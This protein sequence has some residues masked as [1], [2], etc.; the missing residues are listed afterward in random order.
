VAFA[1]GPPARY[2][3][4]CLISVEH[5]T[6]YYGATRA[7]DD[8]SF[9]VARGEVAALLGPNGSGKSTVMRLVIG[10]FSPTAGHVRVGG[11]DVAA[12]PV[13]ARGQV[14][15][16]PEQVTLYPDLTVRR[17][18]AFVAQVK[19]LAGRAARAAVAQVIESCGLGDVADRF[20]GTLSKGYRQRVGLAQALVGDPEVLV[21][22]EPT[23][24]LDPVQTVEMRGLLRGLA[25]RTLLLST[26]ILSEASALCSRIVIL[27]RGRLLAEDTPS[28]LARRLE[29][30]GR[31]TVRVEGP[32]GAVAGALAGIPGVARVE[33]TADDGRAGTAFVVR[34]PAPEPVQRQLAAVVVGH[35]WTRLEVRAEAPSLEDLFVRLVTPGPVREP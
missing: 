18:L 29:G 22:D 1:R 34:A 15:Y 19:G 23:V 32:P 14:G 11:L 35:G 8:V 33:R 7:V 27:A 20:A 4:A 26:H 13:A 21:L 2:S 16:L 6:K 3:F 5:V 10:Y 17:Y 9:T 24:G 30:L 28:A 12:R 31:L 25:G